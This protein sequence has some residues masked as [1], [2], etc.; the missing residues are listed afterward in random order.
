MLPMKPSFES[1][2]HCQKEEYVLLSHAAVQCLP[3]FSLF[4]GPEKW[5]AFQ[6]L[7]LTSFHFPAFFLAWIS[8]IGLFSFQLSSI[9]WRPKKHTTHIITS[10]QVSEIR[11]LEE[12]N[13]KQVRF[14]FSHNVLEKSG[15]SRIICRRQTNSRFSFQTMNNW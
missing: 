7:S 5:R 14:F 1:K 15:F 13:T 10:V 12:G 8:D 3:F 4:T 2:L 11:W 9:Y 6:C